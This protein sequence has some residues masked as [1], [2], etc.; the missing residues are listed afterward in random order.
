[1][2]DSQLGRMMGERAPCR[3]RGQHRK[4]RDWEKVQDKACERSTECLKM[5]H[6]RLPHRGLS[7]CVRCHQTRALEQKENSV[8]LTMVVC[9]MLVFFFNDIKLCIILMA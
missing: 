7:S 8:I 2:V 9:K 4:D 6:S 3:K 5:R 1:M